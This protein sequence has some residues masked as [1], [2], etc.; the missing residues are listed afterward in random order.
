M[1]SALK[2][3]EGVPVVGIEIEIETRL[4]ASSAEWL[5]LFPEVEPG[6]LEVQS[7]NP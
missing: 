7:V 6:R 1:R 3:G 5:A 2:K 4:V